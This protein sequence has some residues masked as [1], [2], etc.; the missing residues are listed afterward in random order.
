M[1]KIP[2]AAGAT[3]ALACVAGPANAATTV[4]GT[5]P[6]PLVLTP[7][8]SGAF[9]SVLTGS[10]SFSD[11]FM[12]TIAGT[13]GVTNAQISTILLNG[14]QNVDFSSIT[15]DGMSVFTQT[16]T[17]DHP[18]TWTVLNPVYLLA[19]NH[20]I[21]VMGNVAGPTGSYSGTINV[22]LAVPEART[23]TMMLLGFGAI[24]IAVRRRRKAVAAV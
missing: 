5:N 17:D 1:R 20:T 2:L 10:G 15:L 14:S 22:Q 11:S 9:S 18:E 13:P 19:G 3:L 23:W 21:N 8:A 6:N 12:F 4:T 16:S 7:P 24:G